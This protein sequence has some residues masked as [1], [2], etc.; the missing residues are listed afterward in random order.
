MA[1]ARK[2]ADVKLDTATSRGQTEAALALERECEDKLVEDLRAKADETLRREREA[3]ARVLA[4]LIPLKRDKADQRLQ[5][6]RARADD[7]LANRDDFLGTVT[8]DLRDLLA[9]IALS[10]HLI[11]DTATKDKNGQELS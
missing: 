9:G 11:S 10:A 2:T 5:T 4:R 1:T 7:A 6:E 8:H 3:S